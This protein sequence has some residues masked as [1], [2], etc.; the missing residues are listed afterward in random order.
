MDRRSAI[1][2]LNDQ[3]RTTFGGGRVQIAPD[4]FEL[5]AALRGRA[6]WVMSRYNRFQD[7]SEHDWGAFNFAGYAFEW[8]IEYRAGDGTGL[9]PDPADPDQTFRVLTLCAVVDL[10]I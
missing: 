9:S 1:I 8:H 5:D 2:A 4:W 3:L 6:L 10:L 7:G